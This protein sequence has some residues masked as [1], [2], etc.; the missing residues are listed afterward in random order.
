MEGQEVR[1][2]PHVSFI[3]TQSV[4]PNQ[5]YNLKA[6]DAELEFVVDEIEQ[7]V[8]NGLPSIL[9]LDPT[10]NPESTVQYL[11]SRHY[12]SSV[13]QAMTHDL[14]R[15]KPLESPT[16][17]AIK[18]VKNIDELRIWLQIVEVEL[19]GNKR[20]NEAIFQSLLIDDACHFY[21]GYWQGKP[22]ATSFLFTKE[23]H[24]GIYLVATA[25]D[26]R[27]L[28]IGKAI[29]NCAIH[30]AHALGCARIDIQATDLGRSVYASLGFKNTGD[31]HVFRI[32]S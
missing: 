25:K 19:M 30:E 20:L 4:W 3:K 28:G 11:K 12:R 21:L 16:G 26:H 5:L 17:L 24:S 32:G 31:I 27:R 14:E 10:R 2:L 6:Q 22:V 23:N 1:Q 9:M 18:L 7:K 13:W 8:K 29:T 15:L